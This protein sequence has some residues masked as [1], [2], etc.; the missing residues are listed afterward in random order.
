MID[1]PTPEVG[2][3]TVTGYCRACPA[4][5][6]VVV[7]VENG[8][9][10]RIRGDDAHPV[11]RGYLCPKGRKMALLPDDP[12]VLDRL[13]VERLDH[14]MR[15]PRPELVLGNRREVGHTN[16]TFTWVI[17]PHERPEPFVYVSP[18]DAEAAGVGD[19]ERVEV[20]SPHGS[21][22]GSCRVDDRLARGT[23]TIPHGFDEPNVG[24]LTATDQDVDPLTGMLTL[25]GVPLSLRTAPRGSGRATL[26]T[27]EQGAESA[28]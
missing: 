27:A 4:F 21:V 11:S 28:G 24:H 12:S 26:T 13:L 20:T 7:T 17:G 5:C 1:A 19:G 9:P 25:V 15:R 6:G 10:V 16:S 8:S 23:I 14:G 22:V 3:R 18:L 2:E